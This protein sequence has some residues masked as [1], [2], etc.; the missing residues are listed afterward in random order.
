[1][2]TTR[3]FLFHKALDGTVSLLKFDPKNLRLSAPEQKQGHQKLIAIKYCHDGVNIPLRL[4]FPK[5]YTPFSLDYPNFG[6]TGQ[7]KYKTF[8]VSLRGVEH[9]DI[10]QRFRDTIKSIDKMIIDT[11]TKNSR[12]WFPSRGGREK[13][14]DVIE[15]G[16]CGETAYSII[17]RGINPLSD[18]QYPDRLEIKVPVRRGVMT[19]KFF[20]DQ[21]VPILDEDA[22][23]MQGGEAITIGM[24]NGL[25]VVNGCYYPKFEAC[26]VQVFPADNVCKE[27]DIVGD[28]AGD[29]IPSLVPWT[30]SENLGS[31]DESSK[32]R[33]RVE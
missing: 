4:Q 1:M 17:K 13:S 2:A 6:D 18:K 20:D 30:T 26:Q 16:Y 7:K 32:K 12:E 33:Q 15:D 23:E 29:D 27:F 3:E 5:M 19:T 22:I 24:L 11:L 9:S 28:D 21:K 10:L 14:R 31:D 8:S 25:W